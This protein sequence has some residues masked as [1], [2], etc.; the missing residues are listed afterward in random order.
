[1]FNVVLFLFQHMTLYIPCNNS[2][3]KRKNSFFENTYS[4]SILGISKCELKIG[5]PKV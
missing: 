1:M 4:L 3:I 2:K 5:Q